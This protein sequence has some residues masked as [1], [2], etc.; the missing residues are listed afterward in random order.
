MEHH[1]DTLVIGAGPAGLAVG[2]CL[3]SRGVPFLMVDRSTGVA[4][5]W[6][7]HY[8]RLHLHTDRDHSALPEL[9]FP[10]RANTAT[11][12]RGDRTRALL[13]RLCRRADQHAARNRYRSAADRRRHSAPSAS[14][15]RV[16]SG[17]PAREAECRLF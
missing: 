5:S 17:L 16:S 4:S 12:R 2:A 15:R 7:R 8:D 10:A 3:K 6:R 14:C 9:P 1:I 11:Q 13:Q